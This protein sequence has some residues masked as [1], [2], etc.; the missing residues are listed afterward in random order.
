MKVPVLVEPAGEGRW[1]ATC[2]APFSCS[3]EGPTPFHAIKQLRE[4][5]QARIAAGAVLLHI[6]VPVQEQPAVEYAGSLADDEFE[7]LQ[8]AIAEYRREKDADPDWP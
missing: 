4:D 5:L 1:R 2:G 8:K 3:A 7:E 6:D